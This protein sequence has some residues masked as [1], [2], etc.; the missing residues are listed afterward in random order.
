MAETV[1]SKKGKKAVSLIRQRFDPS[2]NK[3]HTRFWLTV[4]V[5]YPDKGYNIFFNMQP[6]NNY[7]HS[8]PIAQF[9]NCHF[10]NILTVLKIIRAD[11]GFTIEYSGFTPEQRRILK[12][13]VD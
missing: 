9:A 7:E 6:Q 12:E 3:L 2:R 5:Y 8:F 1:W 10:E 4:N 11:L 13:E